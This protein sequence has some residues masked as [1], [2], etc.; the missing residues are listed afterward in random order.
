LG[1]RVRHTNS[2]SNNIKNCEATANK[3][4]ELINLLEGSVSLE[5]IFFKKTNPG[6]SMTRV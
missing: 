5:I 6:G 2:G 4:D 3:P 1:E